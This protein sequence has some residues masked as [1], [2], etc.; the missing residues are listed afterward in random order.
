MTYLVSP[1]E[2]KQ[3][4]GD[5]GSTFL[6]PIST[7]NNER[8]HE[9]ELGTLMAKLRGQGPGIHRTKKRASSHEITT[10]KMGIS[11]KMCMS[12]MP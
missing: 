12:T 3:S 9:A 1:Y 8:E 10:D 7:K 2:E 6:A 11:W 5:G 4:N